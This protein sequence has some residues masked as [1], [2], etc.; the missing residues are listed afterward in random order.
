M[1]ADLHAPLFPS[2]FDQ[3]T[4]AARERT[5]WHLPR[6]RVLI[7]LRSYTPPLATSPMMP[8]GAR[9]TAPTVREGYSCVVVANVTPLWVIATLGRPRPHRGGRGH[10]Q[11]GRSRPWKV[12]HEIT[13]NDPR[14]LGGV[15]PGI[16]K[17][18]PIH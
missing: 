16:H 12:I 18:V 10:L 3:G 5:T 11:V 2:S 7:L 1:G 17:L 14:P 13:C 6:L 8:R 15:A 4:D 9:S